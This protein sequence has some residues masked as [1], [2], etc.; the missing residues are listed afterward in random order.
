[1]HFFELG[2]RKTTYQ[3]YLVPKGS[4][5][6]RDL[7]VFRDRLAADPETRSKYCSLKRGLA[8]RFAGDPRAYAEHKAD[9]IGG[10]LGKQ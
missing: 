6:W 5:R 7:T 10:V 2:C 1:M 3:A 9:F 8:K 4:R